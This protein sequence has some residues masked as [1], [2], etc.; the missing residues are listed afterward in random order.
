MNHTDLLLLLLLWHYNSGRVLA[1]SRVA[2]HL[3]RSRTCS[4]HFTFFKSSLTS[5]S[6]RDFGLPTGLLVNGF[7]LYIFCTILVSGILFVCPNQLTL[8]AVT[9]FIMFR[10]FISS[11]T[12]LLV[13]ILQLPLFSLLGPNNLAGCFI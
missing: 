4:T 8:C 7:Y 6:H 10:C 13:L 11:S 9:L 2:F 5:S 1:F 3:K 12:S